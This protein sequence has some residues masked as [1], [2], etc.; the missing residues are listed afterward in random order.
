MT[1]DQSLLHPFKGINLREE[2]DKYRIGRGEYGLFHAEPYKSELLPLWRFK[3]PDLARESAEAIYTKY[4][5]YRDQQDFVG[6][7]VARKY[8]QMGYTRA[9]RYAQYKDGRKYD[10]AGRTLPVLHLDWAKL[11]VADIFRQKWQQ[12]R[13]DDLYQEMKARFQAK[14]GAR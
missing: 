4:L 6:M 8:L 5:E 3:T 12:V 14:Y 7:D 1:T 9:R 11:E 10:E 13:D 2:P